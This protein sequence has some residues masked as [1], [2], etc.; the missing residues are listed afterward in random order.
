MPKIETSRVSGHGTE[1]KGKATYLYKGGEGYAE[2]YENDSFGGKSYYSDSVSENDGKGYI[3]LNA[4][5][6]NKKISGSAAYNLYGTRDNRNEVKRQVELT[7][8][9]TSLYKGSDHLKF[10]GEATGKLLSK[11]L[12]EELSGSYSGD[13]SSN[14]KGTSLHY[15]IYT[16]G[17]NIKVTSRNGFSDSVYLHKQ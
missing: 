17:R 3:V 11:D 13:I 16:Q 5:F 2:I 7:F 9:D 12:K 10:N 15:N 4:D 14:G 1:L 8:K 6:D